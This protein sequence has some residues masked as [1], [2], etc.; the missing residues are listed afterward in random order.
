MR[1]RISAVTSSL[2][3]EKGGGS[4]QNR[5]EPR[6]GAILKDESAIWGG[7]WGTVAFFGPVF[8][9]PAREELRGVDSTP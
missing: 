6:I 9:T 2:A 8:V 4:A 7:E 5:S 1:S 3:V